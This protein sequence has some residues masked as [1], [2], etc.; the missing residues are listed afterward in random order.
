MDVLIP[1]PVQ[2][3]ER[4]KNTSQFIID[5]SCS[6]EEIDAQ[7]A[8]YKRWKGEDLEEEDE[9]EEEKKVKL[10]KQPKNGYTYDAEGKY[11]DYILSSGE[12]I[13]TLPEFGK[14]L[15]YEYKSDEEI[16]PI[17]ETK[18]DSEVPPPVP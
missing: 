4:E 13:P 16:I 10:E 12:L 18:M 9:K 2:Q 7:L 17:T 15:S 6:N 5:F 11:L 1:H 8:A 3:E 14:E